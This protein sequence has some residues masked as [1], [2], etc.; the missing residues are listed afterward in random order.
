MKCTVCGRDDAMIRE[1][2]IETARITHRAHVDCVGHSE[3]RWVSDAE[4]AESEEVTP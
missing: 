2:E 1:C 4:I 3:Y